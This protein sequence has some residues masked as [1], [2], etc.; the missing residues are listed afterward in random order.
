MEA[1]RNGQALV[2]ARKHEP[3]ALTFSLVYASA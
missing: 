3:L 2:D 1:R